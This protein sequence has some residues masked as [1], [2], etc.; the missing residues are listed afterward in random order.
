M[1]MVLVVALVLS[2][3]VKLLT[4]NSPPRISTN[5]P[6][7]TLQES[8]ARHAGVVQTVEGNGVG[9]SGIVGPVRLFS[10]VRVPNVSIPV[11]CPISMALNRD[12]IPSQNKGGRHV[13]IPNIQRGIEP[14]LDIRAPLHLRLVTRVLFGH[15]FP[16]WT[17]VP[18][19][20]L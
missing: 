7:L 17:N 15:G 2:S 12:I 9:P 3:Y 8:Y 1:D 10:D 16:R 20:S 14:V 11:E 6:H 19:M 13:L 18:P 4:S 5:S